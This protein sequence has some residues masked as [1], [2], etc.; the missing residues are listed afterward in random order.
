M[1]NH[2]ST[3]DV[4]NYIVSTTPLN[5]NFTPNQLQPRKVCQYVVLEYSPLLWVYRIFKTLINSCIVIEFH[6]VNRSRFTKSNQFNI[7]LSFHVLKKVKFFLQEKHGV[8]LKVE[9]Y[10]SPLPPKAL[11][12]L[13]KV[14]FVDH[15]P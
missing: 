1:K 13:L 6:K 11:I 4:R 9:K 3:L 2:P 5:L 14:I 7:R 15:F 12:W 8:T 10:N